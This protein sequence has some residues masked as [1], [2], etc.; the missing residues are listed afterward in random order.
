ML[1]E[2]AKAADAQTPA[3]LVGAVIFVY[4]LHF[5][6]FSTLP[7]SYRG[8]SSPSRNAFGA[9]GE[10]LFVTFDGVATIVKRW[11]KS[12]GERRSLVSLQLLCARAERS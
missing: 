6:A 10:V 12:F 9:R 11:G 7:F 3:Q 2:L 1:E 8:P 4:F 5:S